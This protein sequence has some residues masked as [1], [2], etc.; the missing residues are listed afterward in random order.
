MGEYL[1]WRFQETIEKAR[2]L[3]LRVDF[4]SRC[5]VAD[6]VEECAR[7]RLT[8]NNLK[9][10]KRFLTHADRVLIATGHW[11]EQEEQDHCFPS[12]WPPEKLLKGI[13]EGERVAIIGS[14]LSALDA[15]LTLTVDG[16]FLRDDNGRLIYFPSSN[17]RSIRLYSR[18]GLLPRVRGKMGV[19]RNRFLTLENVER[20]GAKNNNMVPLKTIF[21]LLE[22]DLEAAYGH[23]IE[24]QSILNPKRTPIELLRDYLKDAQEGD[25]PNGTLLWQTLLHQAFPLLRSLYA[26]LPAEDRERFD[27]DYTTLFFS[28]ASLMPLINGEKL[29]AL[30]ESGTLDVVKLGDDYGFIRD[31]S[32]GCFEFVYRN[33]RGVERRDSCKYVIDARGQK[34]SFETNPSELAKNL[35]RSGTVQIEEIPYS[36]QP[37]AHNSERVD[38]PEKR[39]RT[40]RTGSI[41]ID[42]ETHHLVTKGADGKRTI[43]ETI[44]AVGAMTR[45]QT[46]DASMAYASAVSTAKIAEDLMSFLNRT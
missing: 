46:I 20:L 19:Y 31:D 16:E 40:Y 9:S 18:R 36:G 13:P 25:G 14:S 15:T 24:W 33:Q 6:L 21:R 1:R 3:G 44:Y 12:P 29:L 22:S 7:I 8:V 2:Q 10:G 5:E 35:L 37:K 17:P 32:K 41:W 26:N 38:N 30:M 4:H 11:F 45:G 23:R 39:S 42:P 27:K 34:K 43:S 28:Y